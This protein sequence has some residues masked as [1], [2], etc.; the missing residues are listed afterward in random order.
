MDYMDVE[1]ISSEIKEF[2][3]T[4]ASFH[5]GIISIIANIIELNLTRK[6]ITVVMLYMNIVVSQ[7]AILNHG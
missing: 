5:W 4:L 7:L 6:C 2:F 1:H 3:L